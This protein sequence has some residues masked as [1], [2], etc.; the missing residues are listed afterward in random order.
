MRY[1]RPALAIAT[2]LL[3]LTGLA[4]TAHA[5]DHG[6]DKGGGNL[7]VIEVI[8]NHNTDACG[9][10]EYGNNATTGQGHSLVTGLGVVSSQ[11]P[12]YTVINNTGRVLQVSCMYCA[13]PSGM[14][15]PAELGTDSSSNS[16]QVMATQSGST[17]YLTDK[18]TGIYLGQAYFVT[19]IGNG[20]TT[21]ACST[22]PYISCDGSFT[23]S[24]TAQTTINLTQ[25]PPSLKGK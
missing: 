20:I 22:S 1:T 15:I 12:T 21:P 25:A 5:D 10:I 17:A 24:N 7:C 3:T 23:F 6:K 18:A 4:T 8:G 16:F 9:N 2:T 14:T 13:A 11:P 19:R